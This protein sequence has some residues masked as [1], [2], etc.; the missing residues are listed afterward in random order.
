MRKRSSIIFGS[1]IFVMVLL[2]TGVWAADYPTR[3]I[4]VIVPY[5]AGGSTDTVTRIFTQVFSKH[6]KQSVVVENKP[7]AGSLVGTKELIKADPDGYTLGVC[8]NALVG[9]HHSMANISPLWKE[10]EPIGLF[11]DD[12]VAMGVSVKL[13]I[14]TLKEL[15]D[16]GKKNPKKLN[17]G[18]NPGTANYIYAERL[19]K[20]VGVVTNEVPFRGGGEANV[21]LAGGHIDMYFDTVRVYRPL[22]DAQ[23]VKI[24]GVS[25]ERRAPYFPEIPTFKEQGVDI[26]WGSWN[27]IFAPKGTPP[28]IILALEKAIER[29]VN[30]KQYVEMMEK[31]ISVIRYLDRQAFL[32]LIEEEDKVY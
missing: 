13:G 8:S 22:V 14:G 19:M 5:S 11:N 28:E 12:P 4:T 17:R 32:R 10:V 1:I 15:I 31:N 26:T 24:L 18:V 6:L 2:S 25:S 9:F 3:A 23:K 20:L 30:D 21:A 27:G 7:G 16:F 29:T